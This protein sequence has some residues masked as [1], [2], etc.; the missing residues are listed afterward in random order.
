MKG[1]PSTNPYGKKVYSEISDRVVNPMVKVWEDFMETPVPEGCCIHHVNGDKL[2]NRIE[3]LVCMTE[4]DHICWHAN[5]RTYPIW[6]LGIKMDEE[7]LV[8][9]RDSQKKLWEDPEYRNKMVKAHEGF[10]MPSEQKEKISNSNKKPW[11]EAR[12]KAYERSKL[13]HNS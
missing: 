13:L 2:D 4:Q 5:H 6:N 7:W 1:R 10:K 3:N 11:S 8:K 9:R 12:R